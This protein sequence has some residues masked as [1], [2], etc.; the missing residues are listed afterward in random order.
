MSS[1]QPA[2]D[3]RDCSKESGKGEQEMAV[4]RRET[5]A[6][7]ESVICHLRDVVSARVVA[8]ETGDID[9][10]HVLTEGSRTPKQ[11]VRDIES[12]LMA[13]LG[14][15]LDHRKVSVA[16]I[17]GNGR[18]EISRLRFSDVSISLNGSHAEAAVRLS[19]DGCTFS[20]N[21]SGLGSMNSQMRLIATATLRAVEDSGTVDGTMVI[22]D[23]SVNTI[24]GGKTI[25]VILISAVTDRAEDF[26][27]GSAVVKQDMWKA[28][29]NATL[30]AI[31]RRVTLATED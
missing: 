6:D 29:V 31:N 4:E 28:V 8:G 10:V 15:Q 24:L 2:F 26:L 27:T 18:R 3:R 5:L 12:A 23:M 14:V 1:E 20:G 9:E 25:V 7:V 30:D 17:Q 11:V 13:K 19:R 21:A 22:E 16:Q